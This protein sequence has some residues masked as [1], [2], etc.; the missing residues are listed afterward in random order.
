MGVRLFY[1][2]VKHCLSDRPLAWKNLGDP[3]PVFLTL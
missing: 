2:T 1:F 3:F